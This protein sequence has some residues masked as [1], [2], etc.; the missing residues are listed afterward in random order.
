MVPINELLYR[1]VLSN[2]HPHKCIERGRVGEEGLGRGSGRGRGTDREGGREMERSNLDNT[3]KRENELERWLSVLLQNGI[4]WG[5]SV[6][7]V[8]FQPVV[9]YYS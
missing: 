2:Y 7:F 9:A 4:C 6:E 1:F 5:S 3:V 8:M